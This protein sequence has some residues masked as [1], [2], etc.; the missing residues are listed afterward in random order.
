MGAAL[1][2]DNEAHRP[3][4]ACRRDTTPPPLPWA[5]LQP[6]APPTERAPPLRSRK[7]RRL[8][9]ALLWQGLY[10]MR[11]RT[12]TPPTK[13]LLFPED[14]AEQELVKSQRLIEESHDALL[15]LLSARS[16][17]ADVEHVSLPLAPARKGKRP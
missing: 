8:R 1:V 7:C 15:L 9:G 16:D 4:P 12:R 5:Q 2:R 6:Q 10:Q 17:G 13:Q 3:Q 11:T 14:L